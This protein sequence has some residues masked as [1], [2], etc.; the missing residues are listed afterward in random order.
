MKD[1]PHSAKN[2][3]LLE[4]DEI[5]SDLNTLVQDLRNGTP[6]CYM[7]S[8]YRGSGKSSF[9]GLIETELSKELSIE[10]E[11]DAAATQSKDRSEIVFVHTNFSRYEKKT[12]LL[13]RLIRGLYLKVHN[14]KS[15]EKIKE[16]HKENKD[17]FVKLIE[18]LYEKTF[19]ETTQIF[20][21]S[22]KNKRITV[23]NIDWKLLLQALV[24]GIFLLLFFL[25]LKFKFITPWRLTDGTV[26]I[27]S[28]FGTILGIL[29]IRRKIFNEMRKTEDFKRVSLYDD[30]ISDYHFKNILIQMKSHY[31][32][33]FVLDEMDKVDDDADLESLLKEMKPYLVSGVASFVVVAGQNLYYKYYLSTEI[34]DAVLSSIFSRFIHIPLLT[35]ESFRKLFQKI[36]M[37]PKEV[38]PA[39]R[40]LVNLYV[41]YLIVKSKR[42][43]RQ[44]IGLVRQN[45]EWADNESFVNFKGE[46]EYFETYDK[47]LQIIEKI[48]ENH[49]SN[50]PFDQALKDYF[51]M[52]L[53]LTYSK[54]ER[55]GKDFTED[56]LINLSNE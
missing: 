25:N 49:I 43:P 11:T 16:E 24:P 23:A 47:V 6:T 1:S 53:F 9:I 44:F 4:M 19:F 52:H 26:L 7:V 21:K 37:V 22:F 20:S 32:V 46:K 50:Y 15:F 14:L 2:E 39:E 5:R 17:S 27:A 33:V 51:T 35:P 38:S 55:L 18:T 29:K 13:R 10:G 54:M 40:E 8:G 28:V 42:I 56:S 3:L 31:Q 30:E 45:L 48:E 12:F 41:S 34:D 36:A